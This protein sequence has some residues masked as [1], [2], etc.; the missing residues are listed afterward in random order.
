MPMHRSAIHLILHGRIL[1]RRLLLPSIVSITLIGIT[2]TSIALSADEQLNLVTMM[3]PPYAS[4]GGNVG[5]LELLAKQAFAHINVAIRVNNLTAERALVNVNMGID[6]GDLYR[7]PGFEANYPNLLQ[8]PVVIDQLELFAYTTSKQNQISTWSDLDNYSVAY[9]TGHKI[10]ERKVTSS[11]SMKVTD[12]Y[13]LP[14][15]LENNIV[16]VIL[17]DRCQSQ[18]LFK[19]SKI[20]LHRYFLERIE[21]YMYLHKKHQALVPQLAKALVGMKNDGSFEKIRQRTFSR[22][23]PDGC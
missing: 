23:F 8:V 17:L 15:M 2:S 12:I 9:V 11:K 7:T 20:K 19:S 5:F 4:S 3:P 1:I 16:E 6:D 14:T 21:A 13:E 18:R 10:F 22:V